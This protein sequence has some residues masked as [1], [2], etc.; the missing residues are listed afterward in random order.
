MVSGSVRQLRLTY[1]F[2]K[3]FTI[4]SGHL[5]DLKWSCCVAEIGDSQSF[6]Y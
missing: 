5:D 6:K 3:D 4:H 1:S 2:R